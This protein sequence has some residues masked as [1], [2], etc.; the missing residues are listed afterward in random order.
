MSETYDDE[1]L[2]IDLKPEKISQDTD[3]D[4]SYDQFS[5]NGSNNLAK[6]K[7]DNDEFGN[8]KRKTK[9]TKQSDLDSE[10]IERLVKRVSI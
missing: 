1:R 8:M 4:D 10:F 5:K 7:S 9:M 6:K 3:M 2:V